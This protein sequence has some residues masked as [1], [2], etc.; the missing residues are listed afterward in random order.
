MGLIFLKFHFGPPGEI[1]VVQANNPIMIERLMGSLRNH[2][3]LN[4]SLI[5]KDMYS[6]EKSEK[7]EEYK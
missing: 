1:V 2:G 7:Y 4:L 5:F 6:L 3:H